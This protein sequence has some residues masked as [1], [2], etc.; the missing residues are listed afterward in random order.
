MIVTQMSQLGRRDHRVSYR[1]SGHDRG[2]GFASEDH[3]PPEFDEF[4]SRV[5]WFLHE[6]NVD[7][8][9]V[10]DPCNLED[11]TLC[12]PHVELGQT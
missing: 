3:E 11:D 10:L 12:S 1:Y 9:I 6:Q 7:A 5:I 4:P 2:A 8:F